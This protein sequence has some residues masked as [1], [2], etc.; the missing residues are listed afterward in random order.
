MAKN[1][2]KNKSNSTHSEIVGCL[3]QIFQAEMSGI[4]RYLHYSFMIM[5]HNRIPIQKWFRDQ[6]TEATA[7]AVAVGEKITS[8][9]GHPTLDYVAVKENNRHDVNVILTESLHYEEETLVLYKQLANLAVE[10]NDMALE[11]FARG[12]VLEETDHIDEVKKMLRQKS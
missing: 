9:N 10:F 2:N 12:L 3:N 4:T 1:K 8:Y 6:A 5:G 7:H 11:E